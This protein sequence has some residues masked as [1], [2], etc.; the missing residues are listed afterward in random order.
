MKKALLLALA[1]FLAGGAGAWG[2]TSAAKKPAAPQVT[3]ILFNFL[4][5]E[6]LPEAQRTVIVPA[7]KKALD[8]AMAELGP[9]VRLPLTI[10]SSGGE[11]NKIK[12]IPTWEAENPQLMFVGQIGNAQILKQF[13]EPW[14]GNLTPVLQAW[15]VSLFRPAETP[16]AVRPLILDGLKLAGPVAK[17][18][19]PMSMGAIPWSL[20]GKPDGSLLVLTTY[21]L[22]H[23]S[24][25][26]RFLGN[27][28]QT[29]IE[30]SGYQLAAA[31]MLSTPA[32][33]LALAPYS[34]QDLFLYSEST[35]AH[36]TSRLPYAL[37]AMGQLFAVFPDGRV[38][39]GWDEQRAAVVVDGS[40][41]TPVPWFAGEPGDRYMR[42]VAVGPENTLY[43]FNARAGSVKIFREDGRLLRVLFPRLKQDYTAGGQLVQVLANGRMLIKSASGV[44]LLTPEGQSLWQVKLGP[45][46][47]YA[48]AQIGSAVLD[49]Q[50]KG[51]YLLERSSQKLV[52]VALLAGTE[53][54]G[55]EEAELA[56]L[57]EALAA[58]PGDTSPH[59]AFYELYKKADNLLPAYYHL[60]EYLASNPDDR[61]ARSLAADMKNDFLA[62]RLADW[63]A[64]VKA[65]LRDYGPE[66]ARPQY[67]QTMAG[68][69]ELI[70]ERPDELALRQARLDLWQTFQAKEREIAQPRISLSVS[71]LDFPDLFPSLM[72]Y[73]KAHKPGRVTVK[74]NL[75]EMVR[76]VRARV[77]IKRYMDGELESGAVAKLGPG[78]E[79]SLEL[80]V[81]LNESVFELQEDLP[82]QVSVRVLW[83]DR[84]GERSLEK[85]A[86]VT[87]Y[88]RSA[89][90]WD[91]AAH[92]ASFITPN[93]DTV[94]LFA[95]RAVETVQ[96][97]GRLPENLLKAAA[98]CDY[99]GKYGLRYVPDPA[100]PI[101][102]VLGKKTAVDT[103]RFPRTTLLYQAGDCDDTTALLASLLEAE[104]IPTAI[105]T[106]PGHVFL[107]FDSG[108]SAEN[109]WLYQNSGVEV[110][111]DRGRL[112]IPVETTTLG[113]GFWAC[114]QKAGL[115][116]VRARQAK[117][118][119]FLP[120]AEA[121]SNFAPL[122]LPKALVGIDALPAD[123][124][125]ALTTSLRE[126]FLA[127]LGYEAIKAET[128]KLAGLAGKERAKALIRLGTLALRAGQTD[129]AEKYYTDGLAED[130]K[131]LAGTVNLAGLWLEVK[132]NDQ[133]LALLEGALAGRADSAVIN[134][135]LTQV[136]LAKGN[137]SKAAGYFAVVRKAAPE[138][139]DRYS[140][141]AAQLE[142]NV[143]NG[144]A[145]GGGSGN[146]GSLGGRLWVE[147]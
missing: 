84:D 74:N 135:L 83:T 99:L 42:S 124:V 58:R 48:A 21:A 134:L 15:L 87:L 9:A 119:G 103:V 133:A 34:G 67:Q 10:G 112:W 85:S 113:E 25:D 17:Q 127:K 120:V 43:F 90:T 89:L 49:S 55:A 16:S 63:T 136:W 108:E 139:A 13:L 78:E 79:A 30:G 4:G 111:A 6:D 98:L 7:V 97:V 56:R 123:K 131:S 59:K 33:S 91:D 64:Q 57:S 20:V 126:T 95:K 41:L 28:G 118:F 51:L 2:Q 76:D 8:A 140:A 94:S 39:L 14:D 69:E 53:K 144:R 80:P 35:G 23:F 38:F 26:L 12:V 27:Q 62:A 121:R 105:L 145:S 128:A 116:V 47:G 82:V 125:Q 65:K 81:L 129:K 5:W 114:W 100:S 147:P 52:R 54:L 96:P 117:A 110:I 70:R 71:G 138:L 77:V 141:L 19:L 88:R 50:E 44:E 72:Q 66:T 18:T 146:G 37:S 142:N 68:Y 75:G 92:L 40:K 11:A 61:P 29:M 101:T 22:Q 137:P 60:E 24:P 3:E 115:E 132:K 143:G 122:P 1:W 46:N 32:G 102:Q 106:S 73:Y 93:E 109:K 107:A 104:A 86:A 36:R 45:E 130:P 31:Q